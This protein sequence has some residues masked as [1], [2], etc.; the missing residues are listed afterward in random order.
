VF[1]FFIVLAEKEAICEHIIAMLVPH[2]NFI[3][4]LVKN[5][6]VEQTFRFIMIMVLNRQHLSNL[7][8]IINLALNRGFLNGMFLSSMIRALLLT[9]FINL[10]VRNGDAFLYL[11]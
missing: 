11:F 4:L 8:L 9:T 3:K 1:L 2:I 7:P 5:L 10:F 6:R